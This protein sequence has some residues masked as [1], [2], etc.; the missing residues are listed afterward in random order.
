VGDVEYR[1]GRNE[2]VATMRVPEFRGLGAYIT[3]DKAKAA[4][5][6][7]HGVQA[8]PAWPT[9]DEFAQQIRWLNGSNKMGAGSLAE[10]LLEWLQSRADG[11]GGTSHETF[12]T[13]ESKSK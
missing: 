3:L 2:V 11:V 7:A 10:K 5:E 9:V 6:R 4:V 12:C 13:P 8:T 1:H